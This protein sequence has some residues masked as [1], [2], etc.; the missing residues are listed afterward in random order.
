MATASPAYRS[1]ARLF[2]NPKNKEI[3][4]N[5]RLVR[6][7]G[8]RNSAPVRLLSL[9]ILE[10]LP[11]RVLP[12][13]ATDHGPDEAA[14][15]YRAIV[16]TTLRQLRGLSDVRLRLVPDPL[17]ADEAI[18]FWLLPKL[19]ENWQ[20]DD[21]V[22]R[23]DGWEIDFGCDSTTFDLSAHGEILCPF[24]GSRW[25]HTALLGIGRSTAEVIGPA[26]EGG[27][28]FHCLA[29]DA[30]LGLPPRILPKLPIVRTSEHWEESL[31][32]PLGPALKRAWE[33]EAND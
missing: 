4:T 18:R 30:P 13:M 2:S 6:V 14:R 21:L 10:P 16:L 22:F 9:N 24:L 32:S 28:Y 20:R 11:G 7:L 25:V 17:D 8:A 29:P 33:E 3:F 12:E 1:G 31:A 26:T 5:P 27:H 19:A 23:S 15:R